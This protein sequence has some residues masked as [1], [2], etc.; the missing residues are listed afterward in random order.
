MPTSFL[1]YN[2]AL[3]HSHKINY[4][5]VYQWHS[6][7]ELTD[8]NISY[9]AE[10]L[11]SMLECIVKDM[12]MDMS[13]TLSYDP[14]GHM[15]NLKDQ[16]QK[17]RSARYA[18]SKTI[19]NCSSLHYIEIPKNISCA[20]SFPSMKHKDTGVAQLSFWVKLY[21]TLGAINIHKK[22]NDLLKRIKLCIHHENMK[23]K[24]LTDLFPEIKENNPYPLQ[25]EVLKVA[26][27][28]VNNASLDNIHKVKLSK[29]EEKLKGFLCDIRK[30]F[31]EYR[32]IEAL[33]K[34]YTPPAKNWII[35]VGGRLL[36]IRCDGL[37]VDDFGP[38]LDIQW[39]NASFL[40]DVGR[41]HPPDITTIT[42]FVK[43]YISPVVARHKHLAPRLRITDMLI[44]IEKHFHIIEKLKHRKDRIQ[45]W[46]IEK[47][48]IKPERDHGAYDEMYG[49]EIKDYKIKVGV[50]HSENTSL[51]QHIEN[52]SLLAL[53]LLTQDIQCGDKILYRSRLFCAERP[54]EAKKVGIDY[55]Q[56]ISYH[57]PEYHELQ[58]MLDQYYKDNDVDVSAPCPIVQALRM[59]IGGQWV[60]N[61]EL[62]FLPL[63]MGT[64]FIAETLRYLPAYVG[65]LMLLDLIDY[66]SPPHQAHKWHNI[67]S[68]Q[69]SNENYHKAISLGETKKDIK[70][71]VK[72]KCES[73]DKKHILPDMWGKRRFYQ[74]I[75][76]YFFMANKGSAR[77]EDE[78]E[79]L[80]HPSKQKL[81]RIIVEWLH[82]ALTQLGKKVQQLPFSSKPL[83]SV[84]SSDLVPRLLEARSSSIA[85]LEELL[86]GLPKRL[87]Q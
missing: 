39:Q 62:G 68:N 54:E 53:N 75:D 37:Y 81:A 12:P 64:I 18:M 23:K 32:R 11:V 6:G 21:H 24:V 57:G 73:E 16:E 55:P 66:R 83:Q 30:D 27:Y 35:E 1:S 51:L 38:S 46:L 82:L 7:I 43:K 26:E 48:L 63:I 70:K 45:K 14:T 52:T 49:Q 36:N 41:F 61:S 31:M 19:E 29:D 44:F 4:C 17:I 79:S 28:L 25:G 13:D 3:S 15:K 76:G 85:P 2:D 86:E 22:K 20:T 74:E 84:V 9:T 71:D 56:A 67:F 33:E 87:A 50:Q 40:W 34:S 60:D 78:K 5:D 69:E 58:H 47:H 80:E 8:Y 59:M 77:L 10:D 42:A 72:K 65:S